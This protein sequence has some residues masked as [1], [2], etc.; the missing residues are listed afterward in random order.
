MTAVRRG[1]KVAMREKKKLMDLKEGK[2]GKL[3]I[4]NYEYKPT[5]IV[6]QINISLLWVR[7]PDTQSENKER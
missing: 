4:V 5:K 7:G 3:M 2:A 6:G 1:P